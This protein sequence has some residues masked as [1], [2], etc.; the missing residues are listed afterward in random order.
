MDSDVLENYKNLPKGLGIYEISGPFFFGSAKTYCETI[1][2]LGVNYEVLIIRM[3][4]VPFVDSTGLKNLKE[5]ILQLKNEG[6]YRF[7]RG[8]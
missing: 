1:R 3:R 7:V 2:N 5:T 4:H 8:E 6:T